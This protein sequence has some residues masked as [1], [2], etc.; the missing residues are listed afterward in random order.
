MMYA[1]HIPELT[2]HVQGD[3]ALFI[4]IVASNIAQYVCN[5]IKKSWLKL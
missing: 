3:R 5:Y 4:N 2:G 1:L